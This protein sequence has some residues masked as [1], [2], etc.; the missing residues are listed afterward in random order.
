[1]EKKINPRPNIKLK[2]IIIISTVLFFSL[3]VTFAYIK[4][5]EIKEENRHN[6]KIRRFAVEDSINRVRLE[7][8]K[9]T[10]EME[11]QRKLQERPYNVD[12]MWL[13]EYE[14]KDYLEK[15]DKEKLKEF[16]KNLY[17]FYTGS[18]MFWS[19]P[20]KRI[21]PEDVDSWV[22]EAKN[23]RNKLG[24]ILPATSRTDDL[25]IKVKNLMMDYLATVI[26]E[27]LYLIER[28]EDKH[29]TGLDLRTDYKGDERMYEINSLFNK[30]VNKYD[31]Y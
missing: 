6:E 13:S 5:A 20:R 8:K 23:S 10:E 1:M 4:Y 7:E 9:K 27:F 25:L 26:T 22:N 31:L 16:A 18:E 14:N 24:K 19:T 2:A 15:K 3:V 29:K 12:D 28:Y 11:R 17:D 30:I 21:A